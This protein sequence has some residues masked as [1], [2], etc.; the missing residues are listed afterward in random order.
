MRAL[1]SRGSEK[2]E[3]HERIS[4]RQELIDGSP[5]GDLYADPTDGCL[6]YSPERFWIP[7]DETRMYWNRHA[8]PTWTLATYRT[9]LVSLV[10]L[11]ITLIIAILQGTILYLL[12]IHTLAQILGILLSYAPRVLLVALAVGIGVYSFRYKAVRHR[13]KAAKAERERNWR[14]RL[15]RVQEESE[16]LRARDEDV[17]YIIDHLMEDVPFGSSGLGMV[18][19][20][21]EAIRR[22]MVS[23]SMAVE[24]L[25][26]HLDQID[27][28]E[29]KRL[30][31][32]VIEDMTRIHVIRE[33]KELFAGSEGG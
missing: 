9:A 27:D 26:K 20:R 6:P 17:D 23:D 14:E 22:H 4:P 24:R 18:Q 10:L 21:V 19:A 29:M 28:S 13:W 3:E 2:S 12:S 25:R 11:L 33:E 32:S 7:K 16:R 1:V 8:L 15:Q 30:L 5:P 31:W